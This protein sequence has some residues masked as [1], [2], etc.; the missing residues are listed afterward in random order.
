[1][2]NEVPKPKRVLAIASGGGH[3]V[4]L[5]RLRPAWEGCAVTYASV[6]SS[7]AEDVPGERFVAVPDATRWDRLKLLWMMIRV[8]WLVGRLRPDVIVSTGAAPGYVAIRLGK[9]LGCRTVWLDSIANVEEISMSGQKIG[10]HADLW[11]TQ[12]EHLAADQASSQTGP[13]WKGSVL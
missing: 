8:A 2:T 10:P 6:R 5:L 12:W 7:Y 11:L 3:W 4:Q 9:V 1:M 13:Q